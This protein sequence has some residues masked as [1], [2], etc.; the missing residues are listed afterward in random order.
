ML[1][2]LGKVS[3]HDFLRSLELLTNSNGLHPVPVRIFIN[4]KFEAA[5]AFSSI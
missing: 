5:L 4:P 1:N 3:A 2:C